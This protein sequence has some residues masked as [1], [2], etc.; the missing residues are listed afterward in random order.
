MDLAHLI[1]RC[2]SYEARA[3]DIYRSFAA[4]T[5]QQ[6][7]ACALWT[8]LARE[9][10][11][12]TRALERAARLLEPTEGWRVSLDGWDDAI[13]EI[14][15]RMQQAEDPRIGADFDRQLAAALALERTEMDHLYHRLGALTRMPVGSTDAHLER[16]LAAAERRTDPAVQMQIGMLRA[17]LRLA[18]ERGGHAAHP[19]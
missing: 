13:A 14:D 7:Q 6:P 3:A 2:R 15:E 1:P 17:R 4:R 19:G 5:R 16:L 11:D 9:E 10:E 8:A 12:H 18:H